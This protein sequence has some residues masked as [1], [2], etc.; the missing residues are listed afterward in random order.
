[1]PG[2]GQ[3]GKIITF[4]KENNWS[5]KNSSKDTKVSSKRKVMAGLGPRCIRLF[6]RLFPEAGVCPP[7]QASCICPRSDGYHKSSDSSP[8]TNLAVCSKPHDWQPRSVPAKPGCPLQ[9]H[10][11]AFSPLWEVLASCP[12]QFPKP[13]VL[14]EHPECGQCNQETGFFSFYF[15]LNNSDTHMT[16]AVPVVESC[17]VDA[18]HKKDQ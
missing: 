10:P 7:Q 14:T 12:S 5:P 2:S 18:G 9:Q 6:Y 8:C 16:P 4:E 1:M 15:I 3:K 13:H 11:A 17:S